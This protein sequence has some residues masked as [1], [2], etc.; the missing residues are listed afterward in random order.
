MV[1]AV[2]NP[3]SCQSIAGL[4]IPVRPFVCGPMNEWIRRSMQVAN[5]PGYLD[6]LSRIYEMQVNPRRPL[7]AS[8]VREI[9][10]AYKKR[11]DRQLLELLI[12]HG[13]IFPVK[14]SYVGFLKKEPR[15]L[16]E[17]PRTVSRIAKRLYS[18]DFDTL[19]Y[20]AS[21]PMETNRQLGHAFKKW[22]PELGYRVVD[23]A[24]IKKSKRGILL[25]G[26]GDEKLKHFATSHLGCKLRKGIDLVA[27]KHS[28]YIIGEAKFLTTPGGEQDRGF[29]DAESFVNNR[30]GNATRIAL[31]DGYV[32]LKSNKGLNQRICL[33]NNPIMSAILLKQFIKAL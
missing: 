28:K 16:R 4:K 23:E 30:S 26:G 13:E 32:W 11:N 15:A 6:R 19:M 18:M 22:L 7:E 1:T 33:G 2:I 25:L 21:R 5:S 14:D 20:E 29:D 12:K 9:R 24:E 27:K 3:F 17:N 31:L 10:N 8:A